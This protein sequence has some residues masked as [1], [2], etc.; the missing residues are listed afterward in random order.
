MRFTTASF[1][2][3]LRPGLELSVSYP[4]KSL[5][6]TRHGKATGLEVPYAL[7]DECSPI[8]SSGCLSL[9]DQPLINFDRWIV[10]GNIVTEGSTHGHILCSVSH[11]LR[12]RIY[13]YP[14][15][16]FIRHVCQSR[17]IE[18][19]GICRQRR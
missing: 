11:L 3:L 16:Y 2:F 4:D 1:D 10:E 12:V 8:R 13:R 18:R 19:G 6:C 7:A 14:Q 17:Q 9:S 5:L 15:E